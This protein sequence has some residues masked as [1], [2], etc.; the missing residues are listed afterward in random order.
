M[1]LL[2]S[3]SVIS[4]NFK[5]SLVKVRLLPIHC[6][7]INMLSFFLVLLL[8]C[9]VLILGIMVWSGYKK[10]ILIWKE[11]IYEKDV[12][13]VFK[14]KQILLFAIRMEITGKG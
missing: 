3:S 6:T 12:C 2:I 4:S 7:T 13:P 1:G 14:L 8:F 5:I 11:L 10:R 9:F